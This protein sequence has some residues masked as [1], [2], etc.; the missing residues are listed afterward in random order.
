MPAPTTLQC[1]ILGLLLEQPQSG[2]DVR[3]AFESSP[4]G[5]YSD[6]PGSIYPALRR[7][8]AMGLTSRRA[9]KAAAGRGREVWSLTAA[10]RAAFEGWLDTPL[11][12]ER[13]AEHHD[14][15]LLK[16]AY[17]GL[18]ARHET[19]CRF[20]AAYDEHVG[21]EIAAL[22]EWLASPDAKAVPWTGR[23]A[24]ALGAE[25]LRVRQEW[26]R[27]ALKRAKRRR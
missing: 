9:D 4:L 18:A 23:E 3:R 22:R 2:Y 17:L 24:L 25:V 19:A 27:A 10:G 6:S 5:G 26:A 8:E 13:V 20:L 1:A 15:E 16:F 21:A 11:T 12:R 14:D 7:L